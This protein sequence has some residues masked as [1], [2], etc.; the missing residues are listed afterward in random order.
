VSSD[1]LEVTEL[2]L[3]GESGLSAVRG[4]SSVRGGKLCDPVYPRWRNRC[5]NSTCLVSCVLLLKKELTFQRRYNPLGDIHIYEA[6]RH[7]VPSDP[8]R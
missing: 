3:G 1:W 6:P 5:V 7:A 4:I 8:V 2:A